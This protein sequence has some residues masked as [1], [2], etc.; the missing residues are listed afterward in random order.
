[1]MPG[2]HLCY[3]FGGCLVYDVLAV[4][5]SQGEAT[6]L[7]GLPALLE[8]NYCRLCVAR[9]VSQSAWKPQSIT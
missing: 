5:C 7:L 6:F 4:K 2:E 3:M 9:C 8:P 1:M